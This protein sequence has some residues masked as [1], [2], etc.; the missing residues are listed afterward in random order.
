MELKDISSSIGCK[1]STF[2][3][4]H[5]YGF[6][7]N[8]S[9]TSC[10]EGPL[11]LEEFIHFQWNYHPRLWDSFKELSKIL[12][13]DEPSVAFHWRRGDQLETRCRNGGDTSI[14]CFPAEYFLEKVNA[15][16]MALESEGVSFKPLKVFIATNEEDPTT[17]QSFED[18]GYYHSGQLKGFLHG[19]K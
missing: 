8:I 11:P 16:L 14:N 19:K 10:L 15:T 7:L 17:L 4:L 5:D 18:V 3:D 1:H 12:H 6:Q 2:R 13:F 9:E